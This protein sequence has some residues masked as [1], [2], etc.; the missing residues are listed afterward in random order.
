M[1]P[2]R[3]QREPATVAAISIRQLTKHFGETRVLD[4]VDLNI[5]AG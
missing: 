2:I 5:E 4:R 3:T 1:M